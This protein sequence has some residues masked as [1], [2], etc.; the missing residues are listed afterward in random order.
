MTRPKGASPAPRRGFGNSPA[1]LR[2]TTRR[3]ALPPLA[4][5]FTGQARA[6]QNAG[7]RYP[8]IG[9]GS[10]AGRAD[11]SRGGRGRADPARQA[12]TASHDLSRRLVGIGGARRLLYRRRDRVADPARLC[13]EPGVSA[14]AAPVIA[15]APAAAISR[16]D[17]RSVIGG[18]VYRGRRPVVRA[19]QQLDRPAPRDIAAH[20][21]AV[22]FSGQA[23]QIAAGRSRAYPKPGR[24]GRRRATRSGTRRGARRSAGSEGPHPGLARRRRGVTTLVALFFILISGETFLRRLVEILPRFKN[25]RQVVDISQEIEDDLSVYLGTI[26]MM[27]AAV[28]IAT[29]IVAGL[30]GLGDPLLWG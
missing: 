8:A 21:T 24:R 13:S 16:A 26:T 19:D 15:G 1:G 9:C 29:G 25:K 10:G 2:V 23:D 3:R 27:N 6:S 12:R 5:G 17:Y 28:G 11:G 14:G 7:Y 4:C 18:A 30:C 22:E 20:R